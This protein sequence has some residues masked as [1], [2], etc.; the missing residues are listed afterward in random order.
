MVCGGALDRGNGREWVKY[1]DIA[2]DARAFEEAGKRL[3]EDG[4]VNIVEV[5]NAKI[6]CFRLND[7]I[8]YT[9]EYL[10]EKYK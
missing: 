8:R 2:L 4:K 1:L 7:G 5:N 3:E 10:I 6:K 9:R